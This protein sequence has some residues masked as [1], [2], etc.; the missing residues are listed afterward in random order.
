[1][2]V[3]CQRSLSPSVGACVRE[4]LLYSWIVDR[5]HLVSAYKDFTPD[6]NV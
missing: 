3:A 6:V 1:M 5:T 4:A 2:S